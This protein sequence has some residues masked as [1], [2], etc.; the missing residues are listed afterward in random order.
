MVEALAETWVRLLEPRLRLE[1]ELMFGIR[2]G[3]GLN[4]GPSFN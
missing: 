4:F 1:L 2:Q 3:F